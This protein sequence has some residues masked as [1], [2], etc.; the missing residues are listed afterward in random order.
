[1][2]SPYSFKLS[3][4]AFNNRHLLGQSDLCGCFYC[5]S[6][7]SYQDIT[8]WKNDTYDQTAICPFCGMETV[9]PSNNNYKLTVN[10][11]RKLYNFYFSDE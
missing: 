5:L 8:K 1:M 2:D 11:L 3:E 10:F 4:L 7:F 9:I 6:L